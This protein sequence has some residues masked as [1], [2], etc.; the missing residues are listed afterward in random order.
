MDQPER[1]LRAQQAR[2]ASESAVIGVIVVG[3]GA[4]RLNRGLRRTWQRYPDKSAV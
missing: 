2:S 1:R 4:H 3:A